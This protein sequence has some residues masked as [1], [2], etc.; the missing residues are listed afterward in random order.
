MDWLHCG[1]D[2]HSV[3][4]LFPRMPIHNYRKAHA[5]ITAAAAKHDV[6]VHKLSW[7]GA[8]VQHQR[9]LRKMKTLLPMEPTREQGSPMT[10]M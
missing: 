10:G 4:H 7:S 2:L 6:K 3:H 5:L 1:F 9:H 8:I